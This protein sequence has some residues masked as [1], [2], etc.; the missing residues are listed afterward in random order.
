MASVFFSY[1]HKDEELRDRLEVALATLKRQGLIDTWHDRMLRAGDEFDP[2]IREELERADIIL[3]LVSPDFIASNYCY[4]IEMARALERHGAGEA[5]VIPVILRACDWHPTPFGKLIA[6]PR[7]GKP[8]RSWPD[9]D[10]AFLDVAKKIREALPKAAGAAVRAAPMVESH[11]IP[12]AS[13]GPRS[14]NLRI[15]KTFTDADQ[16]R[17]LDEAFGFMAKFFE[18]SLSELK[19]RNSE[20]DTA[21]KRIDA[22]R[23]TAVIYRNGKAVSRCKI[24]L[25]GM[26]G[27]GI[28]YSSN[29]QADDNSCNDSL[30]VETDAQ[31]MF[32]KP[33]MG[34]SRF[35]GSEKQHLTFEGAAEYYWD[36]LIGH[37]QRE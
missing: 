31:G 1:S 26:L 3:L 24:V 9:L 13:P 29:D 15:S 4:D 14:S 18:G 17:F 32:L 35:G 5:R 8:I 20:I 33:I 6:A 2:G 28:S 37:L 23:F 11:F 16:D 22:N 7:D 12:L 34:M 25:G 30:A 21:F 27:R 36:A 10:E 19:A